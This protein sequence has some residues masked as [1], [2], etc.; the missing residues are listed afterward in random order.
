MICDLELESNSFLK[1]ANL[2]S[3]VLNPDGTAGGSKA[4]DIFQGLLNRCIDVIVHRKDADYGAPHVRNT[5]SR[6]MKDIY[7]STN[8]SPIPGRMPG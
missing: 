8:S 4:C 1:D 2:L 6:N 3:M 7:R 5:W